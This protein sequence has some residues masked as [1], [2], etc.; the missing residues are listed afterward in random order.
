VVWLTMAMSVCHIPGVKDSG[1]L[2]V[3]GG[4][5]IAA[6]APVLA[7]DQHPGRADDRLS[8]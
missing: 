7:D 8:R 3:Q 6:S 2:A 4:Q 5:Q 1:G